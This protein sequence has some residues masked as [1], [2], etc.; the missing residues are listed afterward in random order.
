MKLRIQSIR[1]RLTL[2][3]TLLVLSTLFLFGGLSYYY[4]SRTLSENL[5][6][7]LRN[8]V[9]WVRDFIQPQAG[10][11]KPGRRSIDSMIRR[12]AGQ[13]VPG[14]EVDTTEEADEIWNQIFKHTLQ[15]PKKTYIQ[16]TD[17]QGTAIYRSYNLGNDTLVYSDSVA[18]NASI[19]T[20]G[21]LDGEP[22]RIALARDQ[23]YTYLVGYPLSE[24]RDLLQ[25]LYLIFLILAPLAA[26]VS[27]FGGFALANKSLAPVDD[28]ARRTQRISAESL[29]Q[30]LPVT[31]SDAEIGRL[32]LTI[33][34]M[35][36]RLRDSF[37]QVRQFSADASHEL[38]TPLTIVRGEIELALRTPKTPEA[39]R[40]IL[41][42]T[43]EEIL[44]LTSI[45][46]NLLTL[47]KADR[48]AYQADFSE[49]N[50]KALV[51]ELYED[52]TILAAEKG[53]TVTLHSGPA[54]MLV[55]D[56]V[57]LRQLFLN[58]IDNAIKYTPPGGT[59]TLALERQDGLAVVRV[60][61][62]GIGI[63]EADQGRIF[64]R[65]YRV[66]KARS[67]EMGGAGLGLSIA[68]WIAE[69][70]RG[71]ISVESVQQKGSVFTVSLPLN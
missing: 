52:G 10:K 66:D 35:I 68:K 2:W 16:F 3:Y 56:R 5:D 31:A 28:I 18:V 61:D 36:R 19:L 70:H 13:T 21:W 23:A 47:A 42:S 24:V 7:S 30:T 9:R 63:P 71:T 11:V 58:L 41:E 17:R 59:V 60:S 62:S 1:A 27:I 48:G 44:R 32:T 57:R 37:A 25:N 55:A 12:K 15:S 20:T 34:D 49:V 22:V 69:L 26:A 6:L 14:S 50:L 51:E 43:L 4:T 29:D 46:D 54:I 33:N 53:I 39:Y 67:R 65:F 64:D 38:R 8:E 40:R 45:I